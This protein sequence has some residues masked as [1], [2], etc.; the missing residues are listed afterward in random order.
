MGPLL[1]GSGMESGI[2]IESRRPR[3][4]EGRRDTQ[5]VHD[6]PLRAHGRGR[7]LRS[8][9]VLGSGNRRSLGG[10]LRAGLHEHTA[11]A[12]PEPVERSAGEFYFSN[13]SRLGPVTDALLNGNGFGLNLREKTMSN[14]D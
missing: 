13:G 9:G 11:A 14:I 4:A 8:G 5:R 1:G 3:H 12:E 2:V 10:E 6:Q 7:G